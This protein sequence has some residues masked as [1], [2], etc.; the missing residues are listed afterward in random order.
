MRIATRYAAVRLQ[1]HKTAAAL[2]IYL[3]EHFGVRRGRRRRGRSCRKA[4]RP[5][6]GSHERNCTR[7]CP[8]RASYVLHRSESERRGA[9]A[10]SKTVLS[11]DRKDTCDF[12]DYPSL[13]LSLSPAGFGRPA[14]QITASIIL[15][16]LYRGLDTSS[17]A[18]LSPSLSRP[19]AS[20]RRLSGRLPRAAA[21]A[22][23]RLSISH[24]VA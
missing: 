7:R 2:C 8:S 19:P 6:S 12:C 21:A 16:R 15:P 20:R 10:G 3:V 17:I 24:S 22:G 11:C 13:S 23:P 14:L 18:L 9:A 5:T 1:D 4:A